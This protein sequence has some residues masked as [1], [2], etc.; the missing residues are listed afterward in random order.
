MEELSKKTN[1]DSEVTYNAKM[2]THKHKEIIDL[3][4]ITL[5]SSKVGD[6]I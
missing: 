2:K 3:E 5:C 6:K 4:G 1:D